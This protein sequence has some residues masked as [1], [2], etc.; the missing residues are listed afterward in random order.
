MKMIYRFYDKD[1][2][3]L[4]EKSYS[5]DFGEFVCRCALEKDITDIVYSAFIR[6]S[7]IAYINLFYK[8]VM[9]CKFDREELGL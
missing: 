7:K 1:Y 2:H 3:I 4:E 9:I 8:G 5:Y 6:N